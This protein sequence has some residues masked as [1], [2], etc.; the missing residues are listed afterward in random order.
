MV[1]FYDNLSLEDADRI[2]GLTKLVFDV[3]ENRKAL[4]ARYGVE[5]ETALL[6]KIRS[7]EFG[8]H[9]AYDHYLGAKILDQSREALRNELT[10]LL[11][12][13]NRQ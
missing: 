12:K 4:L 10:E 6:E 5:D 9:P 7:G 2:D 8:E 1:N 13:V 3:R 11:A